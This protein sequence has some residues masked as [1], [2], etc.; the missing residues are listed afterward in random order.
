MLFYF[1]QFQRPLADIKCLVCRL[2]ASSLLNL[3]AP[4]TQLPLKLLVPNLERRQ[5]ADHHAT[6][7][8]RTALW[9][10]HFCPW[11]QTC[12]R[13]GAAQTVATSP[14][15]QRPQEQL[16]QPCAGLWIEQSA[17]LRA[18]KQGCK[19]LAAC[20]P[21]VSKGHLLMYESTQAGTFLIVTIKFFCLCST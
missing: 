5:A 21:V 18:K 16:Q 17:R 20:S 4:S 7:V 13:E 8:A 2:P 9:E 12:T 11:T 15:E 14:Q 19:S 3:Q 6:S 1:T 10:Q